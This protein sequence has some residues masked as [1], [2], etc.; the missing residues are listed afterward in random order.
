[1][2]R[3]HKA[4]AIKKAIRRLQNKTEVTEKMRLPYRV[5]E[6]GCCG[7]VVPFGSEK[8]GYEVSIA[9]G[10]RV[11]PAGCGIYANHRRR[12]QLQRTDRANHT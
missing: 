1:M 5:L 10:K 2:Q 6:S 7:M 12:I 4:T 8:D 11:L 3:S 9:R